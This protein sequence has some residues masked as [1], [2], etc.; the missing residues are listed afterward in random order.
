MYIAIY[1]QENVAHVP[2][3]YEEFR[4]LK[5]FEKTYFNEINVNKVTHN[6]SSMAGILSNRVPTGEDIRIGTIQHFLVHNPS[7]KL[8]NK[9]D[10][11]ATEVTHIIYANFKNHLTVCSSRYENKDGHL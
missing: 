6:N 1:S 5:V 11:N 7:V 8:P 9:E 10:E 3:H 4:D 2:L